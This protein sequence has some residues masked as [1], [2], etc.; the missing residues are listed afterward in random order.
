MNGDILRA[1]GSIY[2]TRDAGRAWWLHVS[3]VLQKH[4]W[5]MSALEP[6]LFYLHDENHKLKGILPSMWTTHASQARGACSM[7]A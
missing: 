6:A 3:S 2:G 5:K 4:G 7:R 1:K